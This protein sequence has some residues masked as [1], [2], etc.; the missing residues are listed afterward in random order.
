M[1]IHVEV[2]PCDMYAYRCMCVE[3]SDVLYMCVY[4]SALYMC[5]YMCAVY[6]IYVSECVCLYVHICGGV[7]GQVACIFMLVPC[8]CTCGG[9]RPVAL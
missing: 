4:V 9:W 6:G 8:T 7:C 3:C 1:C 5:M 2:W